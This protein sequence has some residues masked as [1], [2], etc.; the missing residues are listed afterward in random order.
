MRFKYF[1]IIVLFSL[2][3][4]SFQSSAD[5]FRFHVVLSRKVLAKYINISVV[6]VD[7]V[8]DVCIS[9]NLFGEITTGMH[10]EIHPL[11]KECIAAFSVA[12]LLIVAC[13]V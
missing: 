13:F 2:S 6:N 3:L 10:V 12:Q 8:G 1:Y 11:Y 9:T 5:Y 7:S 4:V